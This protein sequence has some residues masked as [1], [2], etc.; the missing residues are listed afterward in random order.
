MDNKWD[1][2]TKYLMF[3]F[4]IFKEMFTFE[5]WFILSKII[6]LMTYFL[7]NA[8]ERRIVFNYAHLNYK[9]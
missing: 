9:Y 3:L 1:G 2:Y 6:Q 5:D 7:V 8:H 4:V